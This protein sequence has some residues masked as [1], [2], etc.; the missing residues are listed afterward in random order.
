MKAKRQPD[1]KMFFWIA[2]SAAYIHADNPN[3]HKTFT[4]VTSTKLINAKPAVINGL[5]KLRNLPGW[6]KF[7]LVVPF[8]RFPL[9]S[10]DLITFMIFFVS[11]SVRDIPETVL[12]YLLKLS[13]FLSRKCF[14][15]FLGISVPFLTKFD[16]LFSK[17][18][19]S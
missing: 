11:I 3:G 17:I 8:D 13:I 2:A 5:K 4:M 6:H 12:N 7:F 16:K 14:P 15:K 19:F 9:F 10:K 18:G 1:P